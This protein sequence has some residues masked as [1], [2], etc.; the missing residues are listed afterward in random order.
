MWDYSWSKSSSLRKYTGRIAQ[1]HL[2]SSPVVADHP[3]A[4]FLEYSS[5]VPYTDAYY[6]VERETGH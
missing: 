3:T 1:L 4:A 2:K 5:D 6:H